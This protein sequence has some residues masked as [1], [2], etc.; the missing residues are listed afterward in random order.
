MLIEIIDSQGTR[1]AGAF[2]STDVKFKRPPTPSLSCR[3]RVARTA[4]SAAFASQGVRRQTTIDCAPSSPIAPPPGNLDATTRAAAPVISI[5]RRVKIGCLVVG[6]SNIH[7]PLLI[8]SVL[9][10][11]VYDSNRWMSMVRKAAAW[12]AGRCIVRL[13]PSLGRLR[14]LGFRAILSVS[15]PIGPAPCR[16][17]TASP[18]SMPS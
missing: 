9:R 3:I 17:S 14:S 5:C 11:R 4:N 16:S 6:P 7:A 10:S 1:V 15:S 8:W 18:I 13:I 2:G 12:L